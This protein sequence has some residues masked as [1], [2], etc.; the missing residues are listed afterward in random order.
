MF[1]RA[2][3]LL[4]ILFCSNCENQKG[5]S[6]PLIQGFLALDYLI[7]TDPDRSS[8]Y[9]SS[10]RSASVEIAYENGAEPFT[11]NFAT[12]PTTSIWSVTESNLV[13]AFADRGYTVDVNVPQDLSSMEEFPDQGRS[14]WSINQ[15][16]ALASKYKEQSSNFQST[17]FQ[18]VFV[19]GSLAENS[20]VI[21]VTVSGAFG[22]GAPVVF[23]FKE[24]IN[25]FQDSISPDHVKKAEQ[26]TV[27][28][29]LGHALGLV[30]AGIPLSSDHQDTAHGSHCSNTTCGMYWALGDDRVNSFSPGT[31]PLIF[32]SE[33]IADIRNYTP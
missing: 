18:V 24:I 6:S 32:G 3:L 23:V 13:N 29:E 11:G 7:L 19:K 5:E 1:F 9:F 33:C 26:M 27:T 15:L 25:H 8:V 20:G 4:L 16:L 28:H 21:A 17:K 31:N 10:V 22:I 14:T 2:I 30:N 12:A